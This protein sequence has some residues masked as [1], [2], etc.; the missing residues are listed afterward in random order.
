[1][2]L[3]CAQVTK[4]MGVFAEPL[5]PYRQLQ[6]LVFVILSQECIPVLPPAPDTEMSKIDSLPPRSSRFTNS[7]WDTQAG[8]IV[9][10]RNH[11]TNR[12]S[13]YVTCAHH[14]KLQSHMSDLLKETCS[15]NTGLFAL[16]FYYLFT[17]CSFCHVPAP[18]G[19]QAEHS[20]PS[21]GNS[22][23]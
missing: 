11:F 5:A 2:V 6:I 7:R 8:Y 17:A 19:R 21:Q 22:T 16:F 3:K 9:T 10:V 23:H 18:A 1:M 12:K 20:T 15:W 14:V 4:H 13:N